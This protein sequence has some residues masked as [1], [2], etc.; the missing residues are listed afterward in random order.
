M[1]NEEYKKKLEEKEKKLK[2]E[3]QGYRKRSIYILFIN[4]VV[5]LVIFFLF[6]SLNVKNPNLVNGFQVIIKHKTEFFSNEEID[7][8][9]YLINT[10]NALQSFVINNFRFKILKEN[11]PIY[12]FYY[13][14]SVNSNVDKLSSVLVFDL[15]REVTIKNLTAG[16][17]KIVVNLNLNGKDIEVENTFNVKEEIL[18]EISMDPFYIVGEKIYPQIVI[19]NKTSTSVELNVESLEWILGGKSFKDINLGKYKLFSGERLFL[20]SS[21]PFLAEKTGIFTL[22]CSL[23]INGQLNE[24]LNKFLVVNEVE[25]NLEDLKLRIYSDEYLKKNS[26]VKFSFEINN[27]KNKERYILIRKVNVLVPEENYSYE[28]SN[29]KVFLNK[30]GGVTLFELPLM[31]ENSG[32][33]TIIFRLVSDNEISKVL[34]LN[35]P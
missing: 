29:M 31:F 16:I 22:K 35:V 26:P 12:N 3:I 11:I 21:K 24:I 9:V 20:E 10:R 33:H 32:K 6:K 8:K 17:Y 34:T 5:V 14:S 15:K 25:R 13:N 1:R 23:V 4:I 30:Y 27:L 2:E 19:E 18:K 7:A 28:V